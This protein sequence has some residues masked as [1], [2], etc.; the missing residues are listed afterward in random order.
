MVIFLSPKGHQIP[1]QNIFV[2]FILL[3]SKGDYKIWMSRIYTHSAEIT[4]N[5]I[6]SIL[7]RFIIKFMIVIHCCLIS[8]LTSYTEKNICTHKEIIVLYKI[9]LFIS[10]SLIDSIRCVIINMKYLWHNELKIIS[11]P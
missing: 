3:L 4:C 11:E 2:W 8:S 7:G 5:L 6:E 9:A 1:K 10:N